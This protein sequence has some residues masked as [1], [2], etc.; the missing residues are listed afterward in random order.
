MNCD[1]P[2]LK[3]KTYT[4]LDC[5]NNKIQDVINHNSKVILSIHLKNSFVSV[6]NIANCF[7]VRQYSIGISSL[8]QYVN[9]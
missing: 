3:L 1:L 7:M 6:N 4:E 8:Y 9:Y 5:K 2:D